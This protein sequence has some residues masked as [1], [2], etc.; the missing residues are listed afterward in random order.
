PA[1]IV[2][3]NST[4]RLRDLETDELETYTLVYPQDANIKEGKLSIL[5]PIGTAILGYRIGDQLRSRALA[6]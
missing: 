6:G 3:M 5:T 2:T 1:D 4:V